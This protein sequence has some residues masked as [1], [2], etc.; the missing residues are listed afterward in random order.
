VNDSSQPTDIFAWANNIGAA[1]DALEAD[2]FLFNKKYTVYEATVASELAQR[3]KELFLFEMLK[4][5]MAGPDKGMMVRTFEEAESEELVIQRTDLGNVENATRILQQIEEPE[6]EIEIFRDEEHDF[7]RIKGMIVRFSHATLPKP[8]YVVKLVQQSQ[9]LKAKT[10]WVL[11]GPTFKPFA[12]DA[13]VKIAP[14]SHVLIVGNDIFVFHQRKFETLF[15]YNAKQQ[16]IAK[17][18]IAEIERN[19]KLSFPEGA[20]MNTFVKDKKSTIKKLQNLQLGSLKQEELLDH[21]EE[22]GVELL[23]DEVGSIIIMDA[24]D[25]DKFVNLLND[26]Y[27][28]SNLTGRKYEIRSKK[29]LE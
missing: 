24:K 16:Y 10:A 14:E 1:K 23:I 5:V 9:V 20:D 3:L 18:K 26:D 13:G 4:F 19:F 29:A 17:Q 8:F 7:K 15:G 2:L 12:A 11:D 22:M 28:E 27:V 21:A 25:L 6:E